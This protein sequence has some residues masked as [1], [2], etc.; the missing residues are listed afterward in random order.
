M[1]MVEVEEQFENVLVLNDQPEFIENFSDK[2]NARYFVVCENTPNSTL[3]KDAYECSVCGLTLAE[4]VER[5]CASAPILLRVSEGEDVL[6]LIKPYIRGFDYSVVLY[7]STPFVR[8]SHINDLLGY[9]ARKHLSACKLKKGYVLKNDYIER[10]DRLFSI[11]TYDFASDDFF[12]V[13]TLRD[14]EYAG[15]ILKR[16]VLDFHSKNQVILDDRNIT[17]DASVE[18]GYGTRLAG[19]SAVIKK[20][21]IG[22]ECEIGANSTIEGS[23]IGDDVTIGV[24]A[25]IK[26]SVIKDGVTIEAGAL[27]DGSVIGEHSKLGVGASVSHSGLKQNVSICEK[28]TLV[29]ARISE[30]VTVKAGAKVVFI[31]EPTV[32]LEGATIGEC[33]EVFDVTVP[34]KAVISAFSK[35]TKK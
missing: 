24:G 27:V 16:R 17:V 9:V 7:A 22:S 30:N 32:V 26:D 18:L 34:A 20:S 31:E 21:K 2:V 6:P 15:L 13:K 29:G 5:A 23:K 10:V 14:L 35:C 8:K 25:I 33:A 3:P 12:E 1:E 28:S 11:D 4:W 19:G